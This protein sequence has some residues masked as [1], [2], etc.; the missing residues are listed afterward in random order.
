MPID[1]RHDTA[2]HSQFTTTS[3]YGRVQVFRSE[4]MGSHFI[5]VLRELRAEMN[6]AL[7]GWV[8]M[9]EHFHVLIR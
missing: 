7:I 4:R 2:R 1:H 5:D 9:P 8:L 6:F 3:V